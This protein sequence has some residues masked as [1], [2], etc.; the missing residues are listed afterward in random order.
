MHGT[1]SPALLLPLLLL[2]RPPSPSSLRTAGV[3]LVAAPTTGVGTDAGLRDHPIAC[4]GA[5][6]VYLDGV[7][8][9]STHAPPIASVAATVATGSSAAPPAPCA[10][11]PHCDY[12]HGS[13]DAAPASTKEQCCSLCQAHSGCA[14]GVLSGGQ[15]WFKKAQDVAAGCKNSSRAEFACVNPH[16]KPPPPPPAP[17]TPP[18]LPPPAPP[19]NL[20]IP[21]QVPGDLLTDL[22]RAGVIDDPWKDLTWIKNSSLWTDHTWTYSTNFTHAVG[23]SERPG[24]SSSSGKAATLLVFEGVKTGA[25]V[26]VN[27][28]T[29][30]VVRDQFLRYVFE[31]DAVALGLRDGG[32]NRLDVTFGVEDVAEDGR[33]M[34]CTGGWDWVSVL[35]ERA[36]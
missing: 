3:L 15:C 30:G 24:A 27:G 21:A 13:R 12:G 4:A 17:P 10:F 22:H 34:A 32:G 18:P 8:T 1:S 6:P 5:A 7:W 16:F 33:F 25:T 36:G 20:T 9:A 26:R 35:G 2:L 14:A 28:H 29:V 23:A 19:I 11:H 31:L